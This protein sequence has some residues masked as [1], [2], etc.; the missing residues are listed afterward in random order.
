[1]GGK[2]SEAERRELFD[3]IRTRSFRRGLFTL[4]S[5]RQSELYFNLK[6]TMMWPRGAH[7]AARACLDILANEGADYVGGLEMGVVPLIGAMAAL[8]DAQGSPV[9]TFFVRKQPKDHGTQDVIE[10]LGPG[11]TLQGARVVIADDV[12]TTAGSI[13]K[14]LDAAK[15]TGAVIA[16]ALVLVDREEGGAEALAERGVKLLS[17]FKGREFLA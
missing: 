2:V 11:E 6:P 15:S 13:I 5:G 3:L 4:A 16:S 1:M 8:S 12:A 17:V 9:K 10:G 7:L 14:A